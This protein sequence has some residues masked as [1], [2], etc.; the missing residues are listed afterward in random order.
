MANVVFAYEAN[1]EFCDCL[2][3]VLVFA[4]VD[5]VG[6]DIV[7]LDCLCNDCEEGKDVEFVDRGSHYILEKMVL[8][9]RRAG[10]ILENVILLRRGLEYVPKQIVLLDGRL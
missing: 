1:E 9:N 2:N 8:L 3:V 10:D 7:L 4:T 6:S 5:D